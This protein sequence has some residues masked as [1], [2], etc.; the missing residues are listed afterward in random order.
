ME[1]RV[2]KI[3]FNKAGGNASENSYTYKISVPA[4]WVKEMGITK[5]S[6]EVIVAFDGS[7][8]IIKKKIGN[9]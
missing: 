7:K 2:L 6:R 5:D 3:L 1:K 4:T 9:R 8:I